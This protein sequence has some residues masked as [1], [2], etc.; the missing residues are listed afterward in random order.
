M[1]F[2]IFDTQRFHE[3]LAKKLLPSGRRSFNSKL[4]DDVIDSF[5]T[6]VGWEQFYSKIPIHPSAKGK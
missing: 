1:S 4:T 5:A 6:R 3:F 2:S